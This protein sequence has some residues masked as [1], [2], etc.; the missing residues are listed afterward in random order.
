MKKTVYLIS[1]IIFL[2]G[3][4]SSTEKKTPVDDSIVRLH[5]A[6]EIQCSLTKA[7]LISLTEEELEVKQY[8]EEFDEVGIK[9]M[10]LQ[11]K[12]DP[13]SDKATIYAEME[14]F[15]TFKF[16]EGN[17]FSQETYTSKVQRWDESISIIFDDQ[18]EVIATIVVFNADDD[19]YDYEATLSASGYYHGHEI[20]N[21]FGSCR[22]IE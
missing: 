4:A 11:I 7:V 1:I 10:H 19:F 21:W 5:R 8:E 13:K 12:I 2:V 14:L 3:C 9:G 20:F 22:V 18:E 16:P 15:E 6:K 17:A